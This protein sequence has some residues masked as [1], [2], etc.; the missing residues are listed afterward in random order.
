M[1]YSKSA[2]ELWYKP[3]VDMPAGY[4]NLTLVQQDDFDDD[5]KSTSGYARMFEEDKLNSDYYDDFYMFYSSLKGTPYSICV[6]PAII[7]VSPSAGS[8]AGGTN[9][10]ISG[11]GFSND[12]NNLMVY[13]GGLPCIVTESEITFIRCTT[14]PRLNETTASAF[15]SAHLASSSSSSPITLKSLRDFGSQG[16]WVKVW[17]RDDANNRNV[18][19][20]NKTNIQFGWRQDMYFSMFNRYGGWDWASN[21]G[22]SAVRDLYF[23]A[24]AGAVFIAPYTGKYIFYTVGDDNQYLYASSIEMKGSDEKML[25]YNNYVPNGDYFTSSS[26]TSAEIQ[27][28]EGERLFLRYRMVHYSSITPY[29]LFCYFPHCID[30]LF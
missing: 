18:G 16:W 24:D 21:V 29:F 5:Y 13:V 2:D 12:K 20:E 22:F 23:V 25:C 14:K 30:I 26:Q 11:S 19:L 27:L 28:V 10:L 3:S 9:V 6:L 17:D 7:N 8:I 15:M 4:L 1:S